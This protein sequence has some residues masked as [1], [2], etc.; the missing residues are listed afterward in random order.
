M[1]KI[2]LLLLFIFICSSFVYC[3]SGETYVNCSI[4]TVIRL[5]NITSEPMNINRYFYF[6]NITKKVYDKNHKLLVSEYEKGIYT[7]HFRQEDRTERIIYNTQTKFA[8][9]F[10]KQRR[11]Y[12]YPWIGYNGQGNCSTTHKK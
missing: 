5:P 3:S 4:Q 10:G 6:N 8:T 11:G 12:Y 1:K 7:I 2:L 9:L